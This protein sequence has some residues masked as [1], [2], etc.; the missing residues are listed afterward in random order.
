[1]ARFTLLLLLLALPGGLLAQSGAPPKTAKKASAVGKAATAAAASAASTAVDTLLGSKGAA[2]GSLLGAGGSC[3]EGTVPAPIGGPAGTQTAGTAL[4]DAVRKRLSAP[5][6]DSSAAAGPAPIVCV[7]ATEPAAPGPQP[8]AQ[9]AQPPMPPTAPPGGAAPNPG[10]IVSAT[11]AGALITGAAA[12]AP[13]AGKA[14]KEVG[15]LLGRGHSKEH[16][17]KDLAAGRLLLKRVKFIGGSDAMEPGFED[18]LAAV[19]EGLQ[20]VEGRFLLTIPAE[21]PDRGRPDTVM[22]RRRL[23]KLWAHLQVAGVTD[24]RVVLGPYPA[25]D[26]PKAKPPHLGEARPELIR[27]T[28]EAKP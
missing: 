16:I 12:A 14:G 10:S 17:I 22:V 13:L 20:A 21:A 5:V 23:A 3:P 24:D 1:M 28:D 2:V 9:V 26:D 18:D 11:P 15:S 25:T 7:P 27:I 4:V 8:S 6:K 19:A